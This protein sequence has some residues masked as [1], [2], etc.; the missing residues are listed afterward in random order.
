LDQSTR[1]EVQV[2]S[3]NGSSINRADFSALVEIKDAFSKEYQLQTSKYSK[4]FTTDPKTQRMEAHKISLE[5]ELYCDLEKFTKDLWNSWKH[6]NNFLNY[7][8]D[9]FE[10]FDRIV[11]VTPEWSQEYAVKNWAQTEH[12]AKTYARFMEGTSSYGFQ[13]HKSTGTEVAAMEHRFDFRDR[14]CFV[15]MVGLDTGSVLWIWS[16]L[17]IGSI[18]WIGSVVEIGSVLWIGSVLEIRS[19]LWIGSVLEIGSVL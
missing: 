7:L 17:E 9:F 13:R 6:L 1:K 16:V 2:S 10:F 11:W 19:V 4:F 12:R 15:D 5:I 8:P 14:I 3:G 18:L